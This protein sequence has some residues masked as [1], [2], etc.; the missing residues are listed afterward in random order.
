[1]HTVRSLKLGN[2]LNIYFGYFMF[3]QSRQNL[4]QVQ[5]YI[6]QRYN[7]EQGAKFM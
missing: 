1:M 5:V 3:Y 6:Q 4:I 2:A 7:D